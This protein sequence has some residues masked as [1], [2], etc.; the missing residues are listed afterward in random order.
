M[1]ARGPPSLPAHLTSS[2]EH[3]HWRLNMKLPTSRLAVL[4]V[5]PLVILGSAA[6]AGATGPPLTATGSSRR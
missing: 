3:F 1:S 4:I 6:Q 2:K 5:V